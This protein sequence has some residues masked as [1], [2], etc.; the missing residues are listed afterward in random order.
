[1]CVMDVN[2]FIIAAKLHDQID[3]DCKRGVDRLKPSARIYH[4][5]FSICA[6]QI[7]TIQPA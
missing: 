2:I 3:T 7:K 5:T 4:V 1:M 6:M